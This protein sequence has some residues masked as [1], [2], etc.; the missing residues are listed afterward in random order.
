MNIDVPFNDPVLPIG[1]ACSEPKTTTVVVE[2]M[3][4]VIA[5]IE[6]KR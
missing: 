2:Q 1:L 3:G 4:N 5:A 6:C